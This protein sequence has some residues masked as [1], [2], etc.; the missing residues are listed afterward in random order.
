M[1]CNILDIVI[2]P[3]C[4][5]FIWNPNLGGHSVHDLA[6]SAFHQT[7]LS[8]SPHG[9]GVSASLHPLTGTF[10]SVWSESAMFLWLARMTG[11][12]FGFH[13]L[14]P[15]AKS[16]LPLPPPLERPLSRAAHGKEFSKPPFVLEPCSDLMHSNGWVSR[17]VSS[18]CPF[19][20]GMPECSG[21]KV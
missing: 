6:T 20:T 11:C 15:G 17:L 1:P 16:S 18:E 19:I 5:S 12:Y 13:C 8:L 7:C 2:L 4:L 3:D 9:E 14:D 21:P 10:W